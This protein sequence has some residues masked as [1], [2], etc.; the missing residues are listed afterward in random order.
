M[1]RDLDPSAPGC[2]AI[3]RRDGEMTAGDFL[4]TMAEEKR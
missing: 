2:A 3:R 4:A 1:G